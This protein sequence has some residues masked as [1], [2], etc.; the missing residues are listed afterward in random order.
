M[1][2]ELKQYDRFCGTLHKGTTIAQLEIALAASVRYC[3]L[4]QCTID[5]SKQI[6]QLQQQIQQL[7][8]TQPE[9]ILPTLPAVKEMPLGITISPAVQD[10]YVTKRAVEDL[11][12]EAGQPVLKKKKV[13]NGSF[14]DACSSTDQTSSPK[15]TPSNDAQIKLS[16]IATTVFYDKTGLVYMKE[17]AS[18]IADVLAA[19]FVCIAELTATKSAKTIAMMVDGQFLGEFKYPL[20]TTPCESILQTGRYCIYNDCV[21]TMY[22]DDKYLT[23]TSND[24]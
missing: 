23:G 14:W 7:E 21:Q 20:D 15:C 13:V 18:L 5:Y 9:L 12:R 3:R 1:F 2:G 11:I 8:H 24:T 6:A 19:P 22:P 4:F 10:A 17:A 16:K